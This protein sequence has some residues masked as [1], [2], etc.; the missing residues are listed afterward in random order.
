[1]IIHPLLQ[2]FMSESRDIFLESV[3]MTILVVGLTF[4]I[5]LAGWLFSSDLPLQAVMPL[6][7]P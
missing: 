3:K 7:K 6:N 1:M 2:S 4:G 5:I